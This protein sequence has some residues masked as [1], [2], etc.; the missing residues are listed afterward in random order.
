MKPN[1]PPATAYTIP[2]V[3]FPDGTYTMDSLS[4]LDEINTRYPEPPLSVKN[5]YFDWFTLNYG[6]LMTRFKGIYLPT[7]PRT[8][9]SEKS[10]PYWNQTRQAAN[11]GMDLAT[12]ERE[13][14]GEKGWELVRP[15]L[16]EITALLEEN[17]EE[18]PFFEGE[19]VGY[20]DFWWGGFLLVCKRMG[21]GIWERLLQECGSEKGAERHVLLLKGLEK[22]S[23]RCDY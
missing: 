9:L 17:A 8:L 3:L 14:G 1:A 5:R 4:I 12:L 18:G 10:I 19:K 20:V 23:E 6:E 13:I 7:V 21:N 11:G 15:L 16:K 2:T 22:W